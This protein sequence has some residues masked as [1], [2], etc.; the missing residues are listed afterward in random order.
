MLTV[1]GGM[2]LAAIALVILL[3]AAIALVILYRAYE[4]RR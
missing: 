4:G 1:P 3:P 2:M